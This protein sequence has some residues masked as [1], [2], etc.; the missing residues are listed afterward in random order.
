MGETSVDAE[1]YA[2]AEEYRSTHGDGACRTLADATE[3]EVRDNVRAQQAILNKIDKGD[4]CHKEGQ[5]AVRS[6]KAK[7]KS[8]E[9]KHKDADAEYN[10]A[11]VAKVDFGRHNFNSIKKNDCSRFFSGASYT[12]REAHVKKTKDKRTSAAGAVTQAKKSLAAAEEAAV[13]AARK[14]RCRA[15]TN[16]ASALDA[17]NKKV[18]DANTK[19]WTKAAHLKCVLAGK[20]TNQCS[21]PALPKV[22]AVSLHSGVNSGAC[23]SWIGKVAQCR[24]GYVL[25]GN[26]ALSYKLYV[27]RWGSA[28]RW[29]AG[30]YMKSELTRAGT[31]TP[32]TITA[33]ADTCTP[34]GAS[35][36][37]K[38]SLRLSRRA[39]CSTNTTRWSSSSTATP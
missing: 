35:S 3:K 33:T 30:C 22:N 18:K 36:P 37:A 7:L 34:C 26:H 1:A 31:R 29:D 39:P 23:S 19:A 13:V 20:T 16:H 38:S 21:V 32:T 24:Q 8:A 2:E 12:Q 27:G 11:L 15:F 10:K 5:D 6:M 9:K 14:C 28:N 25:G 4:Q 17:A